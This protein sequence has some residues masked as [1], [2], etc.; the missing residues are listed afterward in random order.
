MISRSIP[1]VIAKI[2]ETLFC[3]GC[4]TC[5]ESIWNSPATA[6]DNQE[7]YSCGARISYLIDSL[8]YEEDAACSAVGTTNY[9]EGQSCAPCNCQ[10]PPVL[11][12]PDPATLIFSDEFETD[13]APD[14]TK[15][16]YDLGDGC[17]IGIC[18]WGNDESQYYT[19]SPSNVHASNGVLSITARKEDGFSRPFTSTRMV[20][21]GLASFKYGRVQFRANIAKCK[22]TGTWPALWM[23]PETWQ[24][25]GW[26]DSGEIDVMEAVG[27]ETDLFHGS[28]HT[29][30]WHGGNSKSGSVSAPDQDWHVFEVD[31]Q[32][33]NI[34]FAIDGLVYYQ[35]DRESTTDKTRW[36]FDQEFHLIMN[37]A[38]GGAWGGLRGIDDAAFEGDGQTMEIDYV[39]VYGS[40]SLL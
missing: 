13:G 17:S 39:R 35:F 2:P 1:S 20:T 23:L 16:T 26:P 3:G 29:R 21:R 30:A 5:T 11:D 34:R 22:A 37:I 33:T 40:P 10:A 27:F 19:S 4:E 38:V 28:V 15:W 12:D 18:G 25:G 32:E 8:L 31:W 7:T 14:A 9:A 24:Y 36:P 6:L